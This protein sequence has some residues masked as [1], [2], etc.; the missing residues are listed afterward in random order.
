MKWQNLL[1]PDTAGIDSNLPIHSQKFYILFWGKTSGNCI[2]TQRWQLWSCLSTCKNYTCNSLI[3]EYCNNPG[4]MIYLHAVWKEHSG[5]SIEMFS[6]GIW[7]LTLTVNR[8][9]TL[10][11]CLIP[12]LVLTCYQITQQVNGQSCTRIESQ[13]KILWKE[14][15]SWAMSFWKKTQCCRIYSPSHWMDC[16]NSVYGWV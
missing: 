11:T 2:I 15:E 12:D 13:V 7:N 14:T 9:E 4:D 5:E 8:W 3:H 16:R 1:S 10:L 6:R